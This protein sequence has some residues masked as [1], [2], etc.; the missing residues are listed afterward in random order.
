VPGL[1]IPPAVRRLLA[2]TARGWLGWFALFFAIGASWALAT[3]RYASPDEPAH[4]RKA[5]G[6]VRLQGIGDQAPG[7]P[8]W[9][10][11]FDIPDAYLAPDPGCF[12]FDQTITADCAI[13]PPISGTSVKANTS[14]SRYP[15]LY[16]VV[17]G[18]PT[19]AI[20]NYRGLYAMR[21]ASAALAAGALAAAF[22][23]AGRSRAPTWCR[24]GVLVAITPMTAF[25]TGVVNPNGAEI[26]F[27]LAGW[28]GLLVAIEQ[29]QAG[30]AH[31]RDERGEQPVWLAA[32]GLFAVGVLMRQ[33][34][35]VWL[36]A[37][38]VVAAALLGWPA[39]RR[40]FAVRRFRVALAVVGA[41]VVA[42]FAWLA[43]ADSLGA[44]DDPRTALDPS[45]S[46]G[47]IVKDVVNASM[48]N[49]R[50]MIGRLGW[51]DVPM[52]SI[53]ELIWIVGLGGLLVAAFV[54]AP[55]RPAV[56][57][58]LAVAATWAV[59]VVLE[60]K[61]AKV[62]GYYW[63]G[64]YTLPLAVLVPILAAWV[65]GRAVGDRFP[66]RLRALVAVGLVVGQAAAFHQALRRYMVGLDDALTLR[67]PAWE[68]PLPAWPMIGAYA[69]VWAA[70]C[71][72]VLRRR[73][74]AP[75]TR[76]AP[77]TRAP[78]APVTVGG[79]LDVERERADQQL[80]ADEE[81]RDAQDHGAR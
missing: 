53:T 52:P 40:L 44:V 73:P 20:D 16:Y 56:A 29:Y 19:L 47:T 42:Q 23:L 37:G 79:V 17:A 13:L 74:A 57:L 75:V 63:Q 68:P 60:I 35:V 43:A 4:V 9:L 81:R 49:V 50:E 66:D 39:L 21:L 2:G 25:L 32:A 5:A 76:A 55:R 80:H 11:T 31:L 36:A 3:P 6:T 34:G 45:I 18:A 48:G 8:P 58:L 24:A 64:R 41:A 61:D 28:V 7:Q 14:A 54:R 78:S 62:T 38:A 71:W 67:D 22:V 27:F 26:V 1:V 65:L 59:P 30:E 12:A 70:V 33:L 69:L 51:Y 10:R 72:F 77:L 15:P 46:T